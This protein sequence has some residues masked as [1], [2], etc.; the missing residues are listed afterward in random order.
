MIAQLL[1]FIDI[2]DATRDRG[3]EIWQ[4]VEPHADAI[5]ANFYHRVKNFEVGAQ[6]DEVTIR[7]L[8]VKQK[9][10]WQALFDSR[11]D[12]LYANSVRQ[13]GIQHRNISLSPMWYVAGY[14]GL[15]IAFT[16]L[17]ADA[18]LPP[19]KKGRLI[20]A[21]DKYVAFDMALALSTYDAV[22]VD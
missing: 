22:L 6:I 4:I 16:E 15:K 14:M 10:H 5:I 17:L 13:I 3:P 8:M 2:D 19:I 9:R 20:K 11:F 12:D 7:R 18:P 21:L 1:H